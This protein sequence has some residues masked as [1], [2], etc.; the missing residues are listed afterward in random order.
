M[1]NS[2]LSISLL[3]ALV[4]L[5]AAHAEEVTTTNPSSQTNEVI[6]T[7]S[8]SYSPTKP[9][10]I[11]RNEVDSNRKPVKPPQPE[12]AASTPAPNIPQ[13]TAVMDNLNANKAG[14]VKQKQPSVSAPDVPDYSTIIVRSK[15][16]VSSAT[17]G[18]ASAD[19]KAKVQPTPELPKDINLPGD[20][21][22]KDITVKSGVT[23]IVKISKSYLN[24]FI[25]PFQNPILPTT[26]DFDYYVSDNIVYLTP[27]GPE[28]ISAFITDKNNQK[29]SIN[30]LLVPDNIMPREIVFHVEGIDN[31]SENLSTDALEEMLKLNGNKTDNYLDQITNLMTDVAKGNIP[32][33]YS[34]SEVKRS[35]SPQCR[36]SQMESAPLQSYESINR[37]LIVYKVTNRADA[38]QPITESA[39]YRKGVV[40]VAAYPYVNL[41]PN[42]STELYVLTDKSYSVETTQ[43]REILVK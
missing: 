10:M 13:P 4:A 2:T 31:T 34:Q 27:K 26:S 22:A 8:N 37:R 12:T 17:P 28:P 24:R 11:E 20:S 33:G 15:R 23:Q 9:T 7:L 1:K 38:N 14:E 35:K 5:S 30:V 6:N 41:G 29:T 39:C 25:T 19:Q 42:Q 16:A 36:F 21:D 18:T 40:A 3:S 32:Q 43:K